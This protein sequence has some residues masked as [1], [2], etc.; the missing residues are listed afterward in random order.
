MPRTGPVTRDTTT[1]P[2]GLAQIRI[3]PS[4]AHIGSIAP[5]L[6]V[7]DSL[8][9]MAST[10]YTGET[11]YWDLESGFP[12]GLD[13]TFPLRE[14]NMM[15]CA[16]K[17][18]TPKSLALARGIDPFGEISATATEVG[19][20]TSSGTTSGTITV[21]DDAGPTSEVFTVLFT[22]AT[23]GSIYGSVTG[24]VH[25]FA[26]LTTAMTP[27]N[28]GADH[29][30]IPANYFTGTWAADETYVFQTTEYMA[31]STAY[32]NAHSGS[33]ALG[34]VSA[35]DFVRVE[36]LYTFP[37]GTNT[38]TI[39]FPRTNITSSLN[40]DFQAEDAAAV[41]MTLKSMTASS[42][43]TGGN[44]VWDGSVDAGPNGRIV[45]AGA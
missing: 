34:T 16:F 24:H 32:E 27:D 2:L 36:A 35:P 33:I 28:G 38:M 25:D 41:S 22:G 26:D 37:D 6:S 44:A 43:V 15:E 23:A 14:T 30:T 13:A 18:V 29:F 21:T 20:V 40:I 17:E 7:T 11:E 3:G 42:D 10:S 1:V 8:G 45:F 5:A 12:L 19:S 39:I 4:A 31:G 9:A